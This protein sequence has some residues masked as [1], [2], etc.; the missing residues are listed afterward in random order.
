VSELIADYLVVGAGAS[1]MA[2]VDSLLTH[3]DA[4]IVM[5]DR[6]DRPG[7][8]WL[9]AYPFV[10][11]HQPAANYGVT[12]RKLGAETID[13]SGTNA[14]FYTLSTG[15]EICDYF[16]HTMAEFIRSGRVTF[17]GMHDYLGVDGGAHQVR[18][19][20]TG[21]VRSVTATTLVDATYVQSEVPS[22]HTPSYQIDPGVRCIPPNGLVD[23][24]EPASGFTVI[25][26]GK[27]AMD[28][29]AWLLQN[30]VD[31]DR[32]RWIKRRE[33]MLMNRASM[34]SLD[35]VAT[36]M[37]MQAH[38]IQA[39]AQ[40]ESGADFGERM[41]AA[42]VY[43][44]VDPSTQPEVFRGATLSAAEV[45]ALRTIEQVV[46]AGSVQRIGTDQVVLSGAELPSDPG[47][48]YVDCTAHG[49]PTVTPRPIFA[50][51][52]I[53]LQYVTFGIVPW[54]AATIGVVEALRDDV[55]EKNRLCPPLSPPDNL[56]DV[57]T[58]AYSA[59]LGMAARGAEPDIAEWNNQC[60]LNPAMAAAHHADDPAITE[61]FATI[62]ANYGAALENLARHAGALTTAS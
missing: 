1:G 21:A 57:L 41:E 8:H 53:T 42:G 33:A 49:L 24:A 5:V 45:D 50:D 15:A 46:R 10:R 17:L 30:G 43:H 3:S 29:C 18:S 27:T 56:S 2:F 11:L 19:L 25:G 54:S 61:A 26:A 60:R 6:R 47:E 58:V 16:A 40:A 31:P 4:R 39:A 20:L 62:G 22:R 32:I 28:S 59:L 48:V 9:D 34:Q 7:G 52:V 23:L 51:D 44:R 35:L 55:T 36:Y 37:Q 38:W 14:G 12:S 13:T